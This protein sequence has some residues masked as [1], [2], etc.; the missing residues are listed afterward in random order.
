MRH[1]KIIA[2][3]GPASVVGGTPVELAEI[4]SE[5]AQR[6]RLRSA[7]GGK[8]QASM[9]ERQLYAKARTL[10]SDEVATAL[11]VQPTAA[12]TWIDGHLMRPS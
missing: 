3:I 2:T 9:S 1:T 4:V 11:G 6:Q 5:G 10:L 7:S 8:G 12:E